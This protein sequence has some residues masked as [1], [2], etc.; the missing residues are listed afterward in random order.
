MLENVKFPSPASRLIRRHKGQRWVNINMLV[1][2]PH[3][4]LT[5]HL[6]FD[7][8]SLLTSANSQRKRFSGSPIRHPG[9][10]AQ[11]LPCIIWAKKKNAS[12]FRH[13]NCWVYSKVAKIEEL[14]SSRWG[15]IE[16]S[17]QAYCSLSVKRERE[18][19]LAL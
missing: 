6:C 11:H 4:E 13:P 12:A 1:R 5:S 2:H 3:F 18:R 15:K 10:F 17:A 16:A 14:R 9:C 19:E 8:A 7:R